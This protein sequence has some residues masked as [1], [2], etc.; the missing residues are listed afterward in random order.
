MLFVEPRKLPSGTQSE[1]ALLFASEKISK[2]LEER[3]FKK[4]SEEYI[5]CCLGKGNVLLS[6]FVAFSCK[7]EDEKEYFVLKCSFDH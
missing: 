4:V 6:A 3:A 2:D 1:K 5:F 7:E